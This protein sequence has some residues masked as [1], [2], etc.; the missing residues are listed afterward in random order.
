[1]IAET[2][3]CSFKDGKDVSDLLKAR[4]YMVSQGA[5][6]GVPLPTSFL[7]NLVKGETPVDY[8]WFNVHPSVSAYGNSA[9]ALQASGIGLAVS[10]RFS[11]VADC[12]AGLGTAQMIYPRGEA[13]RV[14]EPPVFIAAEACSYITADS[15]DSLPELIAD[16]NRAIEGMGEYAPAFSTALMPFTL[17]AAGAPD[18]VLYSGFD[19][20]SAWSNYFLELS[21][22]AAGR[23][24]QTRKQEVLDCEGLSIWSSEQVVGVVK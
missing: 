7:W 8:V 5:K 15:R 10:K 22:T 17:R 21:T 3:T 19:S 2:W 9:D 18:V 20:A 24:L 13:A 4:D 11:V 16:L 14:P 1:M 23:G 6:A 12:I